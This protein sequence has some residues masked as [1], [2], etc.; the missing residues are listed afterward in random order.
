MNS[1]ERELTELLRKAD[2]SAAVLIHEMMAAFGRRVAQT[3]IERGQDKFEE[4]LIPLTET[5]AEYLRTAIPGG[6][7][8]DVER[9]LIEAARQERAWLTARAGV[10]H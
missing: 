3:L 10:K 1:P 9:D 5:F 6:A 7:L 8:A 4:M 2:Q